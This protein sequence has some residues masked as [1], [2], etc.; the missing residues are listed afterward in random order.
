[1]SYSNSSGYYV[2][3]DDARAQ[4]A[5]LVYSDDPGYT[6]ALDPK[7]EDRRLEKW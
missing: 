7:M 6:S 3:C 4:G 1:M 2:N 5:Y